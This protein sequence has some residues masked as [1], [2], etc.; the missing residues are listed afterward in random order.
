M[1]LRNL[2]SDR[3]GLRIT[4]FLCLAALPAA[5][6]AQEQRPT[7]GVAFGGGSARYRP[8]WQGRPASTAGRWRTYI[9]I[10]RVFGKPK[11]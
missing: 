3:Q 4:A 9:G 2:T 10:G 5:G 8:F 1:R 7:V 6:A 11:E